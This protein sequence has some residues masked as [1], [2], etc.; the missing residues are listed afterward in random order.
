MK[1]KQLCIAGICVLTIGFF[2]CNSDGSSKII[3]PT[4]DATTTGCDKQINIKLIN[5]EKPGG[6]LYFVEADAQQHVSCDDLKEIGRI[7]TGG[8]T[9]TITVH[10]GKV[11]HLILAVDAE[12]KCSPSKRVRQIVL[13]CATFAKDDIYYW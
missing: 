8:T 3:N 13:T 12:G 1:T 6:I 7:E 2:A 11:G 5:A 10:Q 9:P 4:I